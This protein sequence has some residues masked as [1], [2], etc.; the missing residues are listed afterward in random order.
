MSQLPSSL[1]KKT[2]ACHFHQKGWMPLTFSRQQFKCGMLGLVLLAFLGVACRSH[3]PRFDA[4]APETDPLRGSPTRLQKLAHLDETKFASV[5]SPIQLDPGSLRPPTNFFRLG[6]GDLIGIEKAGESNS[7][8]CLVGPDGRIYYSMLP[9]TNI[10]GLTLSETKDVLEGALKKE[11]RVVPDLTLTLK[12]VGSKRIWILGGIQAPGAYPL[13]TP[14]TLLE[15]LS[16]AGGVTPVAGSPTGLPDL[17][18]SFLMRQGN[19]V[20]VDFYRLLTLGDLSQNVYLQ[21]D[22]FIFI[23]SSLVRDIYVLGAVAAPNIVPYT[24]S[25]TLVSALTAAGGPVPYA[26]VNEVAIVRGSLSSPRI[27][28]VNFKEIY[29]GALP[30]LKLEPGD[31]V[32]LPFVSYRKVAIL[33][34]SMLSQF[35]RTIAVNEGSRAAIPGFKSTSPAI[36]VGGV[37]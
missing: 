4:R 3:G 6:P 33:L 18:N 17:R 7:W 8:N 27:A 13:A 30:D 34:E 19:I 2:E 36:P 25:V 16:V 22:D 24:D 15:A 12:A 31:I 32:Y 20:R 1:L 29:K 21:P 28:M 14:M 37:P 23:R 11:V 26:Q 5:D 35:V 9:G 10:W